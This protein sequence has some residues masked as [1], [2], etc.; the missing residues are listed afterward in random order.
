LKGTQGK[1]CKTV[2]RKSW[3]QGKSRSSRE[4]NKNEEKV[5]QKGECQVRKWENAK[6]VA[7]PV[8]NCN[9]TKRHEKEIGKRK[10]GKGKLI[11]LSRKLSKSRLL[12]TGGIAQGKPQRTDGKVY[13]ENHQLKEQ[14][15][16]SE[17]T[18][19]K[20]S[21]TKTQ[22]NAPTRE[23]EKMPTHGICPP[24]KKRGGPNRM[25]GGENWKRL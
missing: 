4:P 16:I 2:V 17:P 25:W 15:R 5:G 18:I 11:E 6:N 7:K 19:P 23:I 24:A 14:L 12:V 22:K 13:G 3:D 8:P 9:K 1:R 21:N 20:E 10:G